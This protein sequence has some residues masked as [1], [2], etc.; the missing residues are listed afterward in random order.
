MNMCMLSML[1]QMSAHDAPEQR[2]ADAARVHRPRALQ[3]VALV[4]AAV[5]LIQF[6]CF[7]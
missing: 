7:V 4:V 3:Q 6:R 1:F 2:G 5:S